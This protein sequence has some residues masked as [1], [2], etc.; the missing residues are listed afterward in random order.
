MSHIFVS[1]I[2]IFYIPFIG[3]GSAGSAPKSAKLETEDESEDK[4]MMFQA[5]RLDLQ[6]KLPPECVLESEKILQPQVV[7]ILYQ[8][9]E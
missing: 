3:T 6:A 1:F 8:I 7:M 9:L 5:I 4:K 2:C